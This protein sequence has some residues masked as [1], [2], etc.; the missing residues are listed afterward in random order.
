MNE[1]KRACLMLLTL[2]AWL[3]TLPPSEEREALKPWLEQVL[4]WYRDPLG[5]RW[6][7]DA[8][9]LQLNDW[10]SAW[11]TRERSVP[12]EWMR[13]LSFLDGALPQLVLMLERP[14]DYG[15]RLPQARE[16]MESLL[17]ELRLYRETACAQV[18]AGG[19]AV[20]TSPIVVQDELQIYFERVASAVR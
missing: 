16:H 17:Q 19:Q 12:H 18:E 8:A 11:R 3:E 7:H 4:F 13:E 1:L 20:P 14:R 2:Q 15:L 9:V 6:M 10:K 5:K